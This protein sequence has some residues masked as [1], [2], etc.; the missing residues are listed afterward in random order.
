MCDMKQMYRYKILWSVAK[1]WVKKVGGARN[2]NFST[3]FQ[4]T[5][6]KFGQK[7]L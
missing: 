6:A 1:L 4:Q 2:C 5:V 3:E 7:R